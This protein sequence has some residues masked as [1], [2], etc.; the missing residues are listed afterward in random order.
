MKKNIK[1]LFVI[2]VFLLL[3]F[4]YLNAQ[5]GSFGTTDAQN[6]GMGN[7]FSSAFGTLAIGKNPAFIA[8][9]KDTTSIITFQIPNFSVKALEPSLTLDDFNNYF[10]Y[11]TSRDLSDNEKQDMYNAFDGDPSLYMNIGSKL[12]AISWMHSKELGAFAFSTTDYAAGSLKIPLTLIDLV[13]NGNAQNT[14]YSFDNMDLS[15]WWIRMHTLS[16]AREIMEFEEGSLIRNLTG[17]ISLKMVSGFAYAGLEEIDASIATGENNT[18]KGKVHYLARTAF[19]RDM[20]VEYEFDPITPDENYGYGMESAGSGFGVDLGFAADLDHGLRIGLAITDIG[21]ITWDKGTAEYK[22]D[23]DIEINDLFDK[24]QRE[25]LETFLDDSSYAIGSFSTSLPTAL[26][27]SIAYDLTSMVEAIPGELILGL[28]Y[29]QGFNKMPGNSATPRIALG[30]KWKTLPY[31]PII[32]TGFT[33]GRAG[34]LRWTFGLGYSSSVIDIAFATQDLIS[35]LSSSGS[36]YVSAALN[37]IW[38]IQY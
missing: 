22:A 14:S 35:L 15:F 34:N 16:Y 13:L 9:P 30:A 3:S 18:L 10:N 37:F 7:T 2:P 26:R 32:S 6:I 29:H 8:Y 11:P 5:Y 28:G 25:E 1:T 20:G 23:G 27:L 19:S 21:S 33:N 24:D 17:G 12:F 31:I 4:T 36:P 38:K